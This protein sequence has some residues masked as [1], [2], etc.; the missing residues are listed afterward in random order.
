MSSRVLPEITSDDRPADFAIRL[1]VAVFS[2]QR[3]AAQHFGL[4]P[5]TVSRYENEGLTP[6]LG[7]LAGLI[8]VLTEQP[9]RGGTAPTVL[10]NQQQ[11]LLEQ[12]RKL[13][14][15]FPAVYKY[16]D[17]PRTWEQLGRI[18]GEFAS[19]HQ[20]TDRAQPAPAPPSTRR[21]GTVP[22][23][24]DEAGEARDTSPG[25]AFAA[26]PFQVPYLRNPLFI[27]RDE[28]LARIQ[29]LLQEK[30]VLALTGT[31]GLGKTQLAIE[32]AYRMRIHYPGGI[33]W[34]NMEQPEGVATQIATYAGP[35]GLAIPNWQPQHFEYN[36]AAVQ[37][38]WELAIPRL[39]VFDSLEL[40]AVLTRWRPRIGAA[41]IL[42]TTRRS[43]WSAGAGI[44]VEPLAPLPRA[45]SQLLLMTPRA[46]QQGVAAGDL[47]ADAEVTASSA[48]ICAA[49]GDLPLA[50]AM[51]G[52]YLEIYNTLPLDRYL[53]R[54]TQESVAHPSLNGVLEEYLPSGYRSGVV[55]T[56]AL[57]YNQLDPARA[58]D[59]VALQL[60]HRAAQ[61]APTVI[62][63]PLLVRLVGSQPDDPDVA[64]Q[65]TPPLRSLAALG[66]LELLPDNAARMHPLL[67]A[68]VRWRTPT[69]LTDKT[70]LAVALLAE[71]SAINKAG[72]QQAG[73][74]Y[75][76]HV[77]FLL[78]Q[79]DLAVDTTLAD[80]LFQ[81]GDLLYG[82]GDLQAAL[83]L[84]EQAITLYKQ[85]GS[86][87][88]PA[89]V[90]SRIRLARLLRHQGEFVRA[91]GLFEEAISTSREIL[92][93]THPFT[94]A[95][96]NDLAGLLRE[97]GDL[98]TAQ[99]L[100]E[101]ALAMREATVGPLH[102][103]T[104]QSL[105]NLGH[106]RYAQH[107]LHAAETLF[108]RGLQ[109]RRHALG[110]THPDTATSLHNLGLIRHAHGELDSAQALYEQAL[111]VYEQTLGIAH[112][113]TARAV[114]N[115]AR[116]WQDRNNPE[117]ALDLYR[118]AV[119]MYEQA[120]GPQHP[121]TARMRAT[122]TAH[123]SS[124][125]IRGTEGR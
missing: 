40:P 13:V 65:V 54:L 16:N 35:N 117:R 115:L 102:P 101:Q 94:A 3:A 34:L 78:D 109:I 37:A 119:D 18:A 81:S 75:L 41:Q 122:W 57:S 73:Q 26:P 51:A 82:L 105:T 56:F 53:V 4:T 33:F 87:Q 62:P 48:R 92:G 95:G 72:S 61:C 39:L 108:E 116:L 7:Y 71:L 36:L 58:G 111:A 27:D 31:G 24:L 6:P 59:A 104:A 5:A 93:P 83:P 114:T 123:R 112:P 20:A 66:L 32:Y 85:F 45:A 55:A 23:E 88:I 10:A 99:D 96:L 125:L 49:L 8:L 1:R 90:S 74:A 98:A 2:S 110:P 77:R 86:D 121:T 42:I 106:I 120:L 17:P 14:R 107:D 80:L 30:T 29:L 67:A 22:E 38:A 21:V 113:D 64:E 79:H 124:A 46:H 11:V 84:Y 100:A 76:E 63:N 9:A 52:F 12:L 103:E 118:R 50:V 44:H 91:R 68:F 89:L 47:C 25:S 19:M 28:V 15:W 69:A 97:T 43:I 60:L 70:G